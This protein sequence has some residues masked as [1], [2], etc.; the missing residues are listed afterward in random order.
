MYGLAT[1]MH[2][3]TDRRMDRRTDYIIIPIADHN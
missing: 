2:S 3:V 1:I